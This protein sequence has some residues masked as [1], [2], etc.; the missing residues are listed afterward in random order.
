MQDPEPLAIFDPRSMAVVVFDPTLADQMKSP[1]GTSSNPHESFKEGSVPSSSSVPLTRKRKLFK[2]G[3]PVQMQGRFTRS[4]LNPQVSAS[5]L[6]RDDVQ[7]EQISSEEDV[8]AT[9]TC[10]PDSVSDKSKSPPK[11]TRAK[12][13]QNFKSAQKSKTTVEDHVATGSATKKSRSSGRYVLSR[14]FSKRFYSV[15]NKETWHLI[16]GRKILS[17]RNVYWGSYKDIQESVLAILNSSKMISS[18]SLANDFSSTLIYEFYANLDPDIA[19]LNSPRFG[20]IYV[21]NHVCHFSPLI[22]NDYLGC[23]SLKVKQIQGT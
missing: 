7:P 14:A 13:N 4:S 19:T 9:R 22:I 23:P 11:R 18:I 2:D 21:R 12:K 6:K 5:R 10:A 8:S 1:Q 3:S 20:L 16:C 15:K 17:E